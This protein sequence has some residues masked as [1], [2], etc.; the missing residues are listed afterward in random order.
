MSYKKQ[1]LEACFSNKKVKTAWVYVG[2]R[3]IGEYSMN[4]ALEVAEEL[5]GIVV[6]T[7]T[8]EILNR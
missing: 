2:E 4:I 5:N 3:L 7:D 8:G 6:S 1:W